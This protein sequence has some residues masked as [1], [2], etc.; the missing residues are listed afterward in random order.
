M[1]RRTF[2]RSTSAL[3]ASALIP[4]Y[5]FGSSLDSKLNAGLIDE[6]GLQLFS[7]P[8]MLEQDLQAGLKLLA[9]IGYKKIELFGPYSFSATSAKE[10][11]NDLAPRLGFSGS[12][13]FGQE[14]TDFKKI[15]DDFELSCPSAHTDLDT[16]EN[17][18]EDMARA[19]EILGFEYVVLP[20][21]P[22]E[23]RVSMEDY[24]SIAEL[25]NKIGKRA[26]ELNLK[27]AYHNHGYGLSDM[28]GQIPLQYLIENT[29]PEWLFLEMDLFWTTAGRAD[30]IEYLNKYPGRYRLMHVK[31]MKELST[32][33]GDG[34]DPGQWMELFPAMCSAGDGVIELNKIIPTA[35]ESGVKHF[36]VEQDMVR[37]PQ[38]ALQRSA[39]YLK[40]L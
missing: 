9:E 8:L 34:G 14:A 23:K 31:D 4:Q 27:F 12:G 20:A 37:D 36:I 33:S 10:R 30:P 5:N 19:S 6:L 7:V 29:D 17:N 26:R 22:Q 24:K 18:L 15:L 38:T 40:S 28:E 1:K 13:F 16:L 32:F 25:F 35:I 2:I 21:I 11:W 3:G 39:D